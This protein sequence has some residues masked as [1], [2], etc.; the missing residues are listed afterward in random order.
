M[1]YLQKILLLLENETWKVAGLLLMMVFGAGLE[2]LGVALVVPFIGLIAKPDLT[3]LPSFVQGALTALGAGSMRD[4]LLWMGGGLLVLIVFKNVYLAIMYRVEYVFL[5]HKQ[6]RLAV[7]LFDRYMHA[8]YPAHLGRNSAELI[9]IV[10]IDA[11]MIFWYVVNPSFLLVAEVMV[12][13]ALASFLVS[14]A[15]FATL[16]A[17]ATVGSLGFVYYSVLRKK[18]SELGE[19]KQLYY[20]QMIRWVQQGLGAFKEA[21]ILKCEDYF[22]ETYERSSMNYASAAAFVETAHNASRLFIETVFLGG[23]LMVLLVLLASGIDMQSLLPTLAML[24]VA[25]FRLMPSANRIMTSLTSI[26]HHLSYVNLASRDLTA[27]R[28]VSAPAAGVAKAKPIVFEREVEFKDVVFRYPDSDS[29]AL[30]GISF[31]I[32]KGRSTAFVGTSGGGKT[33]ALNVMLGLLKPGQGDVL[34][35]GVSIHE[36]LPAWHKKIGYI[37][38]PVYLYDDTIRRN[39]AFGQKD[40]MIEDARIWSSLRTAQL[41]DFV[42]SLP[43]GL[44]TR[45]GE[46]GVRMSGGQRQ[47]IGIARVLYH[48]PEVLVLDEATT[49][50]DNETEAEI[51]GAISALSGEKTLVIVAHKL[52]TVRDCDLLLH[53]KDGKIVG[54]GSYNELLASNPEFKSLASAR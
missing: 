8:S 38:Q 31:K 40:G 11:F 4:A 51:A 45:V 1:T 32:A 47:R 42:K 41:E 12:V 9:R 39:I 16:L 53:L 10:N 6:S 50:I 13:L 37:P 48:D 20:E 26:R 19:N 22:I 54:E 23:L 17:L 21:K 2:V 29:P 3:L 7:R 36:N 5:F 43:D 24:V 27:P 33:T 35:D 18:L 52:S 49:G 30:D 14:L 15:P 25:A 34:I 46:G 44:D 28:D